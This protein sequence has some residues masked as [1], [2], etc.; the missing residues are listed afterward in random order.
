MD[1]PPVPQLVVEIGTLTGHIHI[2][3]IIDSSF[4]CKPLQLPEFRHR[5]LSVSA[6]MMQTPT[7][8]TEDVLGSRTNDSG[9]HPAL[10]AYSELL[11]NEFYLILVDKTK[12][13]RSP[14][15]L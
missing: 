6:G 1:M 13:W 3:S 14:R 4:P 12:T 9:H 10:R 7:E 2:T 5:R 15:N 8:L 11:Q